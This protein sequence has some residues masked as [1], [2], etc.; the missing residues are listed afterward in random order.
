MR[1]RSAAYRTAL[2]IVLLVAL[3]ATGFSV[4]R[5]VLAA[6]QGG[7]PRPLPFTMESALQ[8]RLARMAY[9][10]QPMPAVDRALFVPDGVRTFAED[11]VGAEWVA[12]KL[13]RLLPFPSDWIA[14]ER[15]RWLEAAWFC[16][17]IVGMAVWVRALT[18]SRT[19]GAFAAFFY[20]VAIASVLRS[21]GQELSHENFA[22]PLLIGHLACGAGARRRRLDGRVRQARHLQAGAAALLAGALMTWDLIQFYILLW[23]LAWAVR[24]LRR[25]EELDAPAMA[26]WRWNLG[27]LAVAGVLSPYLRAHG[28]LF[29]PALLAAYGIAAGAGWMTW[30]RRRGRTVSAGAARLLWFLPWLLLPATALYTASYGH[31]A[32]L[33][34]AKLRFLNG[35]PADPAALN[36]NQR[37]LWTP[38]LDTPTWSLWRA[39]FPYTLWLTPPA[40]VLG[41]IAKKRG[42]PPP[43]P[44]AVV[45]GVLISLIGFLFFKRLHVFSAMMIAALAGWMAGWAVRQRGAARWSVIGL[46]ALCALGELGATINEPR[47]WGRL[48]APYNELEEVAEWLKIQAPGRTVLASFELGPFFLTYAGCPIVLHPKFESPA[49]RARVEEY[50]R[51]LATGSEKD[52]RDWAVAHGAE[53]LVYGLGEELMPARAGMD[54]RRG[55][56]RQTLTAPDGRTLPTAYQRERE[57]LRYMAGALQ[58]SPHAALWALEAAGARP[59]AGTP[60]HWFFPVWQ[61]QRYVVFRVFTRADEEEWQRCLDESEDALRNGKWVMARKLAEDALVARPLDPVAGDLLLR[62]EDRRARSA[63]DAGADRRPSP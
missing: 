14:A 12:G 19:G 2:W 45:S 31:F 44:P 27:G 20:A 52:L 63:P 55:W 62:I 6:Q 49:L 50:A 33:L 13:A 47:R 38:A 35:K 3:Y 21:T 37:I 26:G 10:G 23:S 58:P 56:V 18:G 4:R 61:N 7:R 36:F 28:F 5:S 16:L 29:S 34:A 8:F 60:G 32:D 15:L 46:T 59:A 54:P 48:N 11:T 57:P 17:G 30:Q 42:I 25:P 24:W 1:P 43:L 53:Y 39:L 41:W 9:A 40:L 22:L 51:A